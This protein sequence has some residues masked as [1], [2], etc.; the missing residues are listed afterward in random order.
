MRV[1]Q[2]LR[3]H[4]HSLQFFSHHVRTLDSMRGG[5]RGVGLSERND[6]RVDR[7]SA[8]GHVADKE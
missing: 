4:F 3:E 8:D 5:R 1:N 2:C 6:L 7:S